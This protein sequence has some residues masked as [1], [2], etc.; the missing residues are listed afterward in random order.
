MQGDVNPMSGKTR[1]LVRLGRA[2]LLVDARKEDQG[3]GQ[4]AQPGSKLEMGG[5]TRVCLPDWVQA[6]RSC[7][8]CA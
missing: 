3:T 8:A 6:R 1:V 4:S 7:L 5:E 2:G